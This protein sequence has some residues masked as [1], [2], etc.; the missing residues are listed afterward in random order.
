MKEQK[1]NEKLAKWVGLKDVQTFLDHTGKVNKIQ[2]ENP[3]HKQLYIVVN[4]FT[5]SL[6]VCFKWFKPKFLSIACGSLNE[7]NEKDAWAKVI[8]HKRETAWVRE[9]NM[10][11]SLALCL[12]IEK[13]IDKRGEK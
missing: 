1:L 10:E 13:L 2:F 12:A 6:D 3:E 8:T 9:L 11:P 7:D 5:Q 4:P